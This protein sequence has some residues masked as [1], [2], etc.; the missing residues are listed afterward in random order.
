M[1]SR[2][3]RSRAVETDSSSVASELYRGRLVGELSTLEA[4]EIERALDGLPQDRR[5]AADVAAG[6]LRAAAAQYRARQ[7]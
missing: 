1:P 7:S 6:A 3:P 2:V 5:H 4:D